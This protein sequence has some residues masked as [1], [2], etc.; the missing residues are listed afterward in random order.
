MSK[1]RRQVVT[2]AVDKVIAEFTRQLGS[3][4]TLTSHTALATEIVRLRA[5]VAELEVVCLTR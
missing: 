5:R 1:E 4:G 2:E 3:T